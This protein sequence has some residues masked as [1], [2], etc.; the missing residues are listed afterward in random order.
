MD[1][2]TISK[3]NSTTQAAETGT[4]KRSS[5]E[6]EGEIGEKREDGAIK[7]KCLQNIR[8]RMPSVGAIGRDLLMAK[9][10]QNSLLAMAVLPQGREEEAL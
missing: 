2:K 5:V 1:G 8:E 9:E 7:Q 10:G 3:S 4:G 6:E